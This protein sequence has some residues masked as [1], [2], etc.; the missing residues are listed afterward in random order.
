LVAALQKGGNIVLDDNVT[1]NESLNLSKSVN[2]DLAGKTLTGIPSNSIMFRIEDGATL[3][4]GGGT[5]IAEGYIASANKG[6]V[7]VVN[8]GTYKAEVTT[9]QANGGKVYV[10]D[11]TFEVDGDYGS[12]YLLNHYDSMNK[13]GLIEV[14]GGTFTGFNPADNAAENPKMSFVAAGYES[15]ETSA[16][17]NVW[18][19]K[20]IEAE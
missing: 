17:S 2:I 3:T 19:V 12:T 15:V 8:D 10:N 16:S 4:I 6:G 20:P 1:L 13:V 7:I 11:G 18:T 5:V 9:F 14:T